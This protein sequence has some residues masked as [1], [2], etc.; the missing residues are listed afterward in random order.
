MWPPMPA[1]RPRSLHVAL[2]TPVTMPNSLAGFAWAIGCTLAA[3]AAFFTLRALHLSPVGA[4]LLTALIALIGLVG[5]WAS[6]RQITAVRLVQAAPVAPEQR[7]MQL[8]PTS[9][10]RQ[11]TFE[12][13]VDDGDSA[14]RGLPNGGNVELHND[15]DY[16]SRP[17]YYAWLHAPN[18]VGGMG[19]QA[20]QPLRPIRIARVGKD[21]E[22][23]ALSAH[24]PAFLELVFLE[25][26]PIPRT[27]RQPRRSSS[28]APTEQ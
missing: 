20:P 24:A 8:A 16:E 28:A 17:S 6:R 9:T 12:V 2:A 5:R 21:E 15:L 7:C 13:L 11:L 27:I 18:R 10:I 1:V 19:D 3:M 26:P 22:R 4:V 14:L 25:Q 23:A